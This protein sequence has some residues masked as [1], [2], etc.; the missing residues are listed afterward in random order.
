[1]PHS[2]AE[3]PRREA[4]LARLAGRQDSAS[5]P[6]SNWT[7]WVSRRGQVAR[8]VAQGRLHRLFHQVYAVGHRRISRPRPS[9]GGTPEPRADRIPQPPHG[10]RGLG[11]AGGQPPRPRADRPRFRR[12]PPTGPHVHRCEDQPDDD[13]VRLHV[14]LRVSSVP[15]MFDRVRFRVRR[16]G[17]SS[18]WSP[19]RLQSGCCDRMPVTGGRRL[20]PALARHHGRSGMK[21]LRA[22]LA[23]YL[24][25]EDHKSQLELA[26]DRMLAEH[27]D[28]PAP[29]HNVHLDVWELDRFWPQQNLA[30]ELDGRPYHI[31]V[32]RPGARSPQG[33]RAAKA[34]LD[35]TAL[36]RLPCRA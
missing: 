32:A 35:P 29:Q 7:L 8:R 21:R 36:H 17:S 3:H 34:R 33:H 24:R 14:D 20:R 1:M 23:T 16:H 28:I 5:S 18:V 22:V 11:T 19:S 15:R 12:P 4:A 26:F 31:A 13:D 25:T 30:V 27:P 2:D 6:G 9:P 10:G